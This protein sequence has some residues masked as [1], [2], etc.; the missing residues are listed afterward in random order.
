MVPLPGIPR[1]G[2]PLRTGQGIFSPRRERYEAAVPD[3]WPPR[4][5][6]DVAVR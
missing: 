3:Q 4:L 2:T 5:L 6:G 1:A